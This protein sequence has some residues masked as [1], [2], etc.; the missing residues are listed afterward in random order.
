MVKPLKTVLEVDSRQFGFVA[1]YCTKDAF[2]CLVRVVN[3]SSCRYMVGLFL[4]ISGAFNN[5]PWVIDSG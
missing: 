2:N 3:G 5:A 4:D 1:G